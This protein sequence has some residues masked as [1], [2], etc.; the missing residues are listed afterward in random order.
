M[1]LNT[2]WLCDQSPWIRYRTKIDLL[3]K[4]KDDSEVKRDYEE[5]INHNLIKSLLQ[6]LKEW[7]GQ[8]MRRHN[9]AKLLF[10]KLVFIADLGISKDNPIIK[11][12]VDKIGARQSGD[13]PYQILGN[14]PTVFGG[15]GKDE[16][17]EYNTQYSNR[18]YKDY[19]SR[20]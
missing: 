11:Q 2:S 7:P 17:K 1:K 4:S 14:I 18:R 6:E 9:D 12:V 13:G 3:D 10:H 8:P 16:L 15:S 19:T 5:L 20:C